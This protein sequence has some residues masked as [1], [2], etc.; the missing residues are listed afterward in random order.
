MPPAAVNSR[1]P[2]RGG[3]DGR[4]ALRQAI[5]AKEDAE[6]ARRDHRAAID[7]ARRIISDCEKAVELAGKGVAEAKTI[8][9][10]LIAKAMVRGDDDDVAGGTGLVIAAQALEVQS[11][12]ELE[13]AKTAFQ[14]LQAHQ[15]DVEDALALAEGN[16]TAAINSLLAP[17]ARAALEQLKKLDAQVAPRL[18]LLKFVLEVGTERGPRLRDDVAGELRAE[19][20]M[21]RPL[22]SLRREVNDYFAARIG[23]D[24]QAA[25]HEWAQVRDELRANP[26]AP[27][28]GI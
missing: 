27:L 10:D 20:A 13:A 22:E 26:D 25:M 9:A 7:Q 14:R 6:L 2:S 5:A 1:L 12:G 11:L 21:R 23:A 4:D 15:T 24:V 3:D 18:A 16:I 17:P 8:R 19:E 28:P